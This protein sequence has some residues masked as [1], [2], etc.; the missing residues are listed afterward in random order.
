MKCELKFSSENEKSICYAVYEDGKKIELT[1]GNNHQ[2]YCDNNYVFLILNSD[3]EK[4]IDKVFDISN[5]RFLTKKVEMIILYNN[6]KREVKKR[7]RKLLLDNKKRTN[8]TEN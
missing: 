1:R 4:K 6:Y 5:K 3:D 7:E 8:N 2:V